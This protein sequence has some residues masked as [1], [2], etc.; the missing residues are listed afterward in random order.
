[1]NASDAT[2]TP[3]VGSSEPGAWR[4]AVGTLAQLS[5]LLA[6][7]L[8]YRPALDL[9]L[10][11][12]DYQWVQHAHWAMH[13]LR[14]LLADLDT[15]LRPANTWMLVLDRAV[16]GWEPAGFHLTSIVVHGLCGVL[17]TLAARRL[18][19]ALWLATLTGLL[20]VVSPF[21]SEPA[22]Q[23]AI[24]FENLL[25]AAWLLLILVWP[26]RDRSF[27]ASRT[28]LI[29]SVL[30]FAMAAKETW[31]VT[32][33][34]VWLLE[35]FARGSSFGRASRTAGIVALLAAAY[36]GAYFAAFPSDK[37][38]YEFSFRILAK[39]PH[40][41]AAFLHLE[42]YVPV[43]FPLSWKGVLAVLAVG[44]AAW[45]GW[46]HRD[47]LI[48]VGFGLLVLPSLPTLLVPFLPTRYAAIPFAGFLLVIVGFAHHLLKR[49]G[50]DRRRVVGVAVT[51]LG[52]VAGLFGVYSVSA[53]L[54]DAHMVSRAHGTLLDRCSQV[55]PGFPLNEPVVFVR[56][57]DANP[58]PEIVEYS[59][60]LPKLA[61]IRPSDPMGLI[62]LPALVEWCRH[63]EGFLVKRISAA[64]RPV[65][66]PTGLILVHSR[67]G[68]SWIEASSHDGKKILGTAESR[69]IPR[70]LIRAQ[71]I[72][73]RR[74]RRYSDE[75]VRPIDISFG[76]D[77]MMEGEL[78]ERHLAG[79]D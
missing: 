53:E 30:V 61:F 24:R 26:D 21:T 79:Y 1:M 56:V 32:P 52:A 27:T 54:E 71:H 9:L 70:S 18:G 39:L 8:L 40:Q 20:W 3:P 67:E 47:P 43:E 28:L 58:L 23:V 51:G 33:G 4:R 77:P 15:F 64:S 13:D 2:D 42:P 36:T 44:V 49:L 16:W 59:K 68:F 19:A 65:L 6:A 25:L 35:R 50:S 14:L 57:E 69:K 55:G 66:E 12:D 5:P 34:L 73:S 11:G 48:S 38:Y 17:L 74:A 45:F 41:W 10:M 72:Q 22:I 63:E 37:S 46:R 75:S 60:G 31:V 78:A 76:A 29:G 62:D 7:V